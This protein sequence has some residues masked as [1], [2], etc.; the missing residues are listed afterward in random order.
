MRAEWDAVVVGAGIIGAAIA[1]ELTRRGLRIAIV[2][3]RGVASGATQAAAG[4]LAPYIEAPDRGPLH[5]LTVRS[6]Q[7]YDA[8][9]ADLASDTGQTIEYRRCGSIEVADSAEGAARLEAVAAIAA[10]EGVESR[11]LDARETEA[12]QPG[13]V[14]RRGALLVDAH[15]YV[16]AAALT[17]TLIDA[18]TTGGAAIV[19]ERVTSIVAQAAGVDVHTT[20]QTLSAGAAVVAAGS[21]SEPLTAD[22]PP[23]RPIRGQLL[24]LAWTGEPLT[25]IIWADRCYMVP[26]ISGTVLVGATVEDVGFDER[27]TADGVRRLIEAATDLLPA[28]AQASFLEARAGLRPA[29]PDGV[30][31]IGR[32]RETPAIVYATGHY[33]NGILLAP[34]TAALVADL[35]TRDTS[36]PALALT[37]PGRFC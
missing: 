18:A 31:I 25:R 15:G 2:E 3:G 29:T 37:S 33:R 21:W 19:R 11:W 13:L 5:Q 23:V 14:A 26:W 30:P 35:M 34:L 9:I 17:H 16:A 8:F 32:S 6:L 27:T 7:M 12:L 28:T 22:A 10:S 1:R 20:G 24:R 4:V 36:D